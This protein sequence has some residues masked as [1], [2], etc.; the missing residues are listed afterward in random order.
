MIGDVGPAAPASST[1][2]SLDELRAE[3]DRLLRQLRELEHERDSGD[4]PEVD[5]V[6][7]R[8][9]YT[10]RAAAVLDRLEEIER[11]GEPAQVAGDAGRAPG[12]EPNALV[13]GT[14]AERG[15]S[16]APAAGMQLPR[17][18]R[19][20]RLRVGLVV[21]GLVLVGVGAG[22][23]V[24]GTAGSRQAGQTITGSFP[25]SPA[26]DLVAARQ[27]MATGDGTMALKLYRAVLQAEP[28]QPEALAYSGWLLR[29]AG[30]ADNQPDLISQ[31]VAAERAAEAADP[32]YPDPHFFLGLILLDDLHDPTAAVPQLQAYLASHPSA[33]VQSSVAPVLARAQQ[34]AAQAAGQPVTSTT[35]P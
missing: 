13:G 23:L 8:D 27:A 18:P 9:D 34:E 31:A 33:A 2:A 19:R 29:L 10:A 26:Q 15:E 1:T 25:P 17:S 12:G 7:L 24:S 6:A 28:N 35:S 14:G 4:L 22:L 32:A 5:F 11:G 20:H 16:A 21:A 30:D 3:R